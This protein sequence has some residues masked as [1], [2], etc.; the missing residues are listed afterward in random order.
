MPCIIACLLHLS[1]GYQCVD[2]HGVLCLPP[3]ALLSLFVN[4]FVLVDSISH[5]RLCH[6]QISITWILSLPI[7]VAFISFPCLLS[8]TCAMLDTSGSTR[9]QCR[10]PL[11]HEIRCLLAA[12]L[13]TPVLP[14][15][16]P[17]RPLP[18][19]SN[20]L[21]TFSFAHV[22]IFIEREWYNV[23]PSVPDHFSWENCF[24]VHLFYS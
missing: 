5:I 13:A 21:Y 11:L 6:L 8:L 2:K 15:H 3:T 16:A 19:P 12:S 23:L 18:V 9:R 4:L 7:W 24:K 1:A 20:H 22:D 17:T 14:P 10:V